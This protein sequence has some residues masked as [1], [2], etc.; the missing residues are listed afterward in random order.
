LPCRKCLTVGQ[1][2]GELAEDIDFTVSQRGKRGITGW[3]CEGVED[4]MSASDDK[5]DG[6]GQRHSDLGGKPGEGIENALTPV[7]HIQMV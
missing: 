5:I 7:S 3:V 4:V 2:G 6:Q 1:D